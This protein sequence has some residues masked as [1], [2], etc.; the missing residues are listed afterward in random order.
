MRRNYE[1]FGYSYITFNQPG[2]SLPFKG[3][4]RV[5]MGVIDLNFVDFL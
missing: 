5:G 2:N 1:K 3:R 4:V